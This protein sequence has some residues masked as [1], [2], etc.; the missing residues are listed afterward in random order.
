MPNNFIKLHTTGGNEVTIKADRIEFFMRRQEPFSKNNSK[1]HNA[2]LMHNPQKLSK[3][4][5]TIFAKIW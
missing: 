4:N 3:G 1:Q 2:Q 5:K